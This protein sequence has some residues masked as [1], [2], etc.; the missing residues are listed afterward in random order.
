M[1]FLF[2]IRDIRAIRGQFFAF[3]HC[4]FPGQR[5]KPGVGSGLGV[6]LKAIAL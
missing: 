1:I 3:P 6:V 4:S 2:L 5:D